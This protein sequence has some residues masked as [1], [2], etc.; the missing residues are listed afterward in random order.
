MRMV[1]STSSHIHEENR[2]RSVKEPVISDGVM[3]QNCSWKKANA[4]SETPLPHSALSRPL[5]VWLVRKANE[6]SAEREKKCRE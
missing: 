5:S 3:A 2:M 6:K 4:N 1:H